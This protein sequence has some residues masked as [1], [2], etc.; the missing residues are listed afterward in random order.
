MTLTSAEV[1]K[2]QRHNADL[3]RENETLTRDNAEFRRQVDAIKRAAIK[4]MRDLEDCSP[5]L[6]AI[7]KS[8]NGLN[9]MCKD[10]NECFYT[11]EGNEY[12]RNWTPPDA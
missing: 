12:H 10:S 11:H 2:M 7:C 5:T 1:A 6:C 9:G 8:K 3:V 4:N